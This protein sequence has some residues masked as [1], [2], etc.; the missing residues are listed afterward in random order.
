[1]DLFSI[2]LAAGEGKR[3]KS[4]HAKPL[5]KA[6]GKTLVDWVLDAAEGAGASQNIVVIGHC[7]Q[8]METYLGERVTY[9]YQ[10]EQLGTGHAV[11]Q[12]IEPIKDKSGT[13]MV[14]CGDTPLITAETLR[15]AME[16]HGKSGRAVTVITAEVENPFGYGR[17]VREN[18]ALARITEQK[19]ATEEE[20]QIREINS[21]MY[22]FDIQKLVSALARLD[23]NNAQ[24]EYYLTDVIAILLSDGEKGDTYLADPEEILGVNDRIQLAEADTLLNRRKVRQLMADGVCVLQ[25]D[26]VRADANVKVGRDTVIYPGTIL[27]GDTQIGEACI[28][29]PNTRL[30]DCT[31]GDKTEIQ[32]SVALES[33]VGSKTSVGPFAYIRPHSTIGSGNKVGDFV[34]VKNASIGDGT[35]IAHLT[36]VGDADVGERVNFGCGTVVVN[37]DG[38]SKHRTVIEDDCFIGCNSN[39]VSPVTV[40]KGA[41]TAAGSTITDEVPEDA[42]AIARARQVN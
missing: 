41:Y 6:G 31:I 38:I 10:H 8:E 19:D 2:I 3:M 17:I 22:L 26:S 32:Y 11:M 37:Y 23:N 18:G 4:A 42:L 35:K 40:R 9:T 27:E 5:Q 30:K 25:P 21:G 34:E 36:Y 15:G 13:V 20:K 1:M 12:G 33:S 14:L 7:A 16:A 28:I 29:G 24:G 39:L